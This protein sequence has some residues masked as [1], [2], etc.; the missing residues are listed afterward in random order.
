MVCGACPGLR[1]HCEGGAQ[2][3]A[4]VSGRFLALE[5]E[6]LA[7]GRA[8]KKET[9]GSS[10]IRRVLGASSR[11]RGEYGA[12]LDLA[13]NTVAGAEWAT[14]ALPDAKELIKGVLWVRGNGGGGV[15]VSLR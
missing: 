9:P 12:P 3:H 8:P 6:A 13:V 11:H 5:L 4:R 10:G 7:L 2:T 1:A 15:S 14:P